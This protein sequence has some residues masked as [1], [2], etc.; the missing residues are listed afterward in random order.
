[1]DS[2]EAYIHFSFLPASSLQVYYELHN[3]KDPF[4]NPLLAQVLIDCT[5][6]WSP[7][8][9]LGQRQIHI[10]EKTHAIPDLARC[11]GVTGL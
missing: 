7:K 5:A 1:M 6:T 11:G 10:F 9:C 2:K 4:K 3:K 8:G